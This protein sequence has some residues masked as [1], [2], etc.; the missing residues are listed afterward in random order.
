MRKP[1]FRDVR[2]G[3]TQ[4]ARLQRLASLEI[5]ALVSIGIILSSQ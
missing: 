4:T 3:K 2:P 1:V 5:L